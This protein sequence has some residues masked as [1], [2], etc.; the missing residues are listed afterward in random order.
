MEGIY[1]YGDYCSGRI[2]GLQMDGNAW[3]S[4]E[5][6]DTTYNITTFGEDQAG[7]LYLADAAG[8]DIFRLSANE[9]A[10]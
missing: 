8:G 5:L 9:S 4:Q 2:W 3:A 10:P 7:E 1:F 6:L